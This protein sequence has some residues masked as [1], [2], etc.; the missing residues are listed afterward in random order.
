MSNENWNSPQDPAGQ[1]IGNNENLDQRQN[2]TNEAN[3]PTVPQFENPYGQYE[4]P[5]NQPQGTNGEQTN[6]YGQP[7]FDQTSQSYPNPAATYG[8]PND[9]YNS[10]RNSEYNQPYGY[11]PNAANQYLSQPTPNANYGQALPLADWPKR[12]LGGLVDYVAPSLV[13]SILTGIFTGSTSSSNIV[14]DILAIAAL[15]FMIYNTG[16]LGGTTGQSFGRRIAHTRLIDANTG[17]VIG[18]GKSVLRWLAHLIDSI[19]C[20]VGWLFPLWDQ[21]RQTL[22]DKICNT[23]VVVDDPIVGGSGQPYQY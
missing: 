8:Q 7:S 20:Y 9:A 1:P 23:V 3:Q 16:Y 10:Q 21:K 5:S 19:I 2:S 22:A 14:S 13:V 4:N 6:P 12:A 18:F 17:Q 11:D 15:G